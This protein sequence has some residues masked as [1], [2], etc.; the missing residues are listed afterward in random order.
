LGKTS[1][2]PKYENV[3]DEFDYIVPPKWKFGTNDRNTLDTKAKYEY[4]F[5]KETDFDAMKAD[6]VRRPKMVAPKFGTDAR[7]M[8]L[9]SASKGTPGPKYDP[10]V[11][12]E[13]PS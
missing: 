10:P 5:R 9:T 3:T 12:P 13:I 11:R 8:S 4:Y 7:F 2:G 6:M 1:P